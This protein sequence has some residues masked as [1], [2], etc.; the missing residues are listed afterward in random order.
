MDHDPL[1][2]TSVHE[3]GH[4]V[5]AL[6]VGLTPLYVTNVAD[7]GSLGRMYWAQGK[8]P[9]FRIVEHLVTSD[10]HALAIVYVAGVAAVRVLAET[11]AELA[12]VDDERARA[13]ARSVDDEE[14]RGVRAL[15]S[16]A[17]DVFSNEHVRNATL[18]LAYQLVRDRVVPNTA[19]E[20]M[21]QSV[22]LQRADA[23]VHQMSSARAARERAAPC[24]LGDHSFTERMSTRY[25]FGM[26]AAR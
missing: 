16:L 24:I 1:L 7:Q 8:R 13:Y 20:S 18:A 25:F 14:E 23:T 12:S 3:C 19:I 22:G 26:T 2:A 17:E 4:G 9:P 21:I 5:M 11:A 15:L 10:D 6:L